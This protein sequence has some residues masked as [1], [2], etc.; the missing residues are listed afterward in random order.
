RGAQ[1]SGPAAEGCSDL[2]DIPRWTIGTPCCRDELLISEVTN[3]RICFV[4]PKEPGVGHTPRSILSAGPT[5]PAKGQK[6]WC[7]MQVG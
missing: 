1:D 5:A 7:G 4:L 2:I 3:S 6:C